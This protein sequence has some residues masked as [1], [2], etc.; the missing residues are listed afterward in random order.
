M[1]SKRE[2]LRK[3]HRPLWCAENSEIK[4]GLD[5]W[6]RVR[7]MI[8]GNIADTRELGEKGIHVAQGG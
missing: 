7:W 5:S 2:V 4:I 6:L 1:A 8:A 3:A